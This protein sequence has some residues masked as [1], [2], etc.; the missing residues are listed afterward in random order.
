M[1]ADPDWNAD[2]HP[3]APVDPAGIAALVRG[4]HALIVF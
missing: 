4:G 1:P 3:V 2:G